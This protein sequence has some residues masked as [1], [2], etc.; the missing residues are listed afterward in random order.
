MNTCFTYGTRVQPKPRQDSMG[1]LRKMLN[2]LLQQA[3]DGTLRGDLQQE[4]SKRLKLGSVV[5]R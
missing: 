5:V 2:D 4:I 3:L 1:A